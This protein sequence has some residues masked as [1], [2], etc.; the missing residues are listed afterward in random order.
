M[1]SCGPV[2]PTSLVDLLEKTAEEAKEVA[3]EE[4]EQEIDY[5]EL[6]SEDE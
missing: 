3:K 4:E 5:E 6:L 1:W 2:L